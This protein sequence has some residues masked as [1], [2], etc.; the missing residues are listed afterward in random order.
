LLAQG[1]KVPDGS[2]T[3]KAIDY[4]IKHWTALTRYC[5]D[6]QVPIEKTGWKTRYSFVYWDVPTGCLQVLYAVAGV[7]RPS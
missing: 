6:G 1:L 2:G 5:E 4:S 3:A 7:Q